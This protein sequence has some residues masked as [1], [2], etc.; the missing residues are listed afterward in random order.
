M[1]GPKF[2]SEPIEPKVGSADITAMS[3]GEPGLPQAFTWRGKEYRISA[4]R[5]SRKG[6][7]EDRG[8][9]YVRRHYYEIETTSGEQMTIYFDRNPTGGGKH[10]QRWWLYTIQEP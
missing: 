4:V 5:S 8:D 3:R 2:V 1:S 10:K 6:L 7:K 9:V